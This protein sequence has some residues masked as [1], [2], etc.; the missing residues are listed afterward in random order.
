MGNTL[1]GI[2]TLQQ[3]SNSVLS[4]PG[5]LYIAQ[6]SLDQAMTIARLLRLAGR[7]PFPRALASRLDPKERVRWADFYDGAFYTDSYE[8]IPS[9]LQ[10]VPTGAQSTRALLAK[11]EIVLGRIRMDPR[12]LQLYDKRWF[13]RFCQQ[14]G[15]SVPQTFSTPGQIPRNAFPVFFKPA[16]EQGGGARGVAT[17]PAGLPHEN[18]DRYIYQEFIP[19]P[20]TWGVSFLAIDG[21]PLVLHVHRELASYPKPGGSAVVIESVPHP[22]GRLWELTERFLRAFRYSGWGL[23]EYKYDPARRDFVFM[24][25]NAKFWASCELAFVNEP[26]FLEYL[27]DVRLQLPG[28]PRMIFFERA[29]ARGPL[30]LFSLLPWLRGSKIIRYRP[31]AQLLPRA[32]RALG[33]RL[34][35]SHSGSH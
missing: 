3:E 9:G 11:G 21:K 26:R 7:R 6:P 34:W 29:L 8:L 4:E 15:L 27:F 2:R 18:V 14:H 23:A 30:F 32:C 19:D 22:D 31:L 5:V 35:R 24:E 28:V 10:V 33:R 25:V 17:S 12:V 16:Q 13:V 1:A 20:V